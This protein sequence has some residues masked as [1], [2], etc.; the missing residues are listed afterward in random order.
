MI[1]TDAPANSCRETG[2]AVKQL[3]QAIIAP[4]AVGNLKQG[5]R[6]TVKNDAKK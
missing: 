5:N 6:N 3:F 4:D 2:V 1:C